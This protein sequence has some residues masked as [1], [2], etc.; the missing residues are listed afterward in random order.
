MQTFQNYTRLLTRDYKSQK[1]LG[2]CHANP[3]TKIQ[4]TKQLWAAK[5]S[6]NKDAETKIVLDKTKFTQ[7]FHKSSSTKDNR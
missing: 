3:T 5:L 6:I 4:N 1:I 2:R 7:S